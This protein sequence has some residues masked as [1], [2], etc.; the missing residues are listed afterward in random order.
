MGVIKITQE[1]TSQIARERVFKALVLESNT[2][3]PKLLPQSFKS[4]DILQGDGGVGSIEQVNFT[5]CKQS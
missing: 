4:I 5:E 3:L 1:F 2:I